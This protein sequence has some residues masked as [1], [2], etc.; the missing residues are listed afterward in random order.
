MKTKIFKYELT[1][2]IF[3]DPVLAVPKDG[4]IRHV[5]VQFADKL[6]LWIEVDP[7]AK[8]ETR[9]FAVFGTGHEIDYT[10]GQLDYIG[11]VQMEG[12]ALILH[13]YEKLD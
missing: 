1:P 3:F 8:L 9:R 6:C 11:T 5:A 10:D 12:G 7:D 13:V 4:I 2:S